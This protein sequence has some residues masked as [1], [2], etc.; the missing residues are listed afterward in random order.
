MICQGNENIYGKNWQKNSGGNKKLL[1]VMKERKV[2]LYTPL[3]KWYLPHGLRLTV[4]HQLV[5]YK[6]GK[7]FVWFPEEVA[8]A[9]PETDKDLLKKQLG[10]VAKLK[11][12]R[13]YGKII[14]LGRHKSTKF[15]G[16]ER[17]VGKALKPTFFDNLE[18]IGRAYEI[19]EFK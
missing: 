15:T 12:N 5:E 2:F 3:I 19:K 10:D 11:G 14:D 16:E 17:V 4:V 7:R 1:G 13:F 18:E 6:P 8:D 9:R